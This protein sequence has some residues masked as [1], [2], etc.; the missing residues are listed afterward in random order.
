MFFTFDFT[1]LLLFLINEGDGFFEEDVTALA[2]LKSKY[3]SFCD[4]TGSFIVVALSMFKFTMW[5]TMRNDKN[6]VRSD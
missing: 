2:A 6:I 4:Y 5:R 1:L 3:L